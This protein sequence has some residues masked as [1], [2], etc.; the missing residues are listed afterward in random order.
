MSEDKVI[1]GLRQ[2]RDD[3]L[4]ALKLARVGEVS[5]HRRIKEL[6]DRL[7]RQKNTIIRYQSAGEG[8]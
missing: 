8:A 5:A 3:L 4:A 7:E 6:G 2:D 1:D